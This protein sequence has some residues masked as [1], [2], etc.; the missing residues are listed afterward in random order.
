MMG[1]PRRI[2]GPRTIG[3]THRAIE[4]LPAQRMPRCCALH[5]GRCK[6]SCSRKSLPRGRQSLWPAD[7][8]F[9][10]NSS[11]ATH[12]FTTTPTHATGSGHESHPLL[13]HCPTLFFH[14]V[15][16]KRPLNAPMPP[17]DAP[18]SNMSSA[19]AMPSLSNSVSTASKMR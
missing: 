15:M 17:A 16:H 6:E 4:H 2:P 9:A 13:R 8:A 7:S 12:L 3:T 11:E 5:W 18:D 1:T 10:D 14:T 19:W